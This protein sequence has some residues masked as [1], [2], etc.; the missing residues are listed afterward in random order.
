[1]EASVFY[2]AVKFYLYI[3]SVSGSLELWRTYLWDRSV[4][5]FIISI[6]IIIVQ[7]GDRA[8]LPGLVSRFVIKRSR[9][10]TTN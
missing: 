4:S 2:P 9:K 7:I 5:R 10:F 1:M 8:F 6:I 3:F